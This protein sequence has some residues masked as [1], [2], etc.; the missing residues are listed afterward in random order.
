MFVEPAK[1]NLIKCVADGKDFDSMAF[2]M[3]DG[4]VAVCRVE[5]TEDKY[6]MYEALGSILYDK[7]CSEVILLNDCA[8]RAVDAG[9]KIDETE[10]PL[11]YPESM[12]TEVLV[13]MHINFKN[14]DKYHLIPYK[15]NGKE[16]EFLKEDIFEDVGGEIRNSVA[17]GF[18][19]KIIKDMFSKGKDI[20]WLRNNY[21][22]LSGGL[23]R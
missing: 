10:L 11:T 6:R 3:I 20:T 2:F 5:L 21:P 8:M 13:F 15:K 19:I 12:R 7:G 16:V 14:K 9:A 18:G 23:N 4:R 22:N 1:Q 17:K